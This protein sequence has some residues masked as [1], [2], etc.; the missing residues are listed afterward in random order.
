MVLDLDT[1]T[2][3]EEDRLVTLGRLLLALVAT[4]LSIT[5]PLAYGRVAESGPPPGSPATTRQAG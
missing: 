3:F 5:T 4:G 2:A 1:V